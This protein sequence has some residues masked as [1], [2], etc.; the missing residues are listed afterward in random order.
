MS[1]QHAHAEMTACLK[2]KHWETCVSTD[3]RAQNL[4]AA[5]FLYVQHIL[6][7]LLTYPD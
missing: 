2:T 7:D 1:F 5:C 6:F 3:I 4:W